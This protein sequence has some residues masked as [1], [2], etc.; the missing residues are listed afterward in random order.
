MEIP[1][2]TRQY[3]PNNEHFFTVKLVLKTPKK[4]FSKLMLQNVVE[5]TAIN[6]QIVSKLSGMS[7]DRWDWYFVEISGLDDDL[8]LAIFCWQELGAEDIWQFQL[9]S[10]VSNTYAT[11]YG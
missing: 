3:H 5:V 6:L 4:D 7:S 2:L 11:Y 1:R 9:N 8:A 10:C